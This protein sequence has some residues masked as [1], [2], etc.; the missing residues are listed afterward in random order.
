MRTEDSYFSLSSSP[1]RVSWFTPSWGPHLYKG[2]VPY[3][4]ADPSL[5]KD[6][7]MHT[8]LLPLHKG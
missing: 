7:E 6:S 8:V 3:A 1:M 2:H 4:L 5:Q